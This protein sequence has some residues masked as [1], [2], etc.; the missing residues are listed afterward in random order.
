MHKATK[1]A[2]FIY[3]SAQNLLLF[4]FTFFLLN[5]KLKKLTFKLL[6]NKL[7]TKLTNFFQYKKKGL[8]FFYNN[9]KLKINI[10]KESIIKS[11]LNANV[12]VN[13]NNLLRTVNKSSVKKKVFNLNLYKLLL[14]QYKPTIQLY[15][16]LTTYKS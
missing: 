4:F 16:L 14:Q 15:K 5:I 7:L 1:K 10:L 3:K 11:N 2:L 13:K 8:T 9:K 12:K 6:K